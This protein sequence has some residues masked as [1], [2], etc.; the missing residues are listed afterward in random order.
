MAG[1]MNKKVCFA[2]VLK[3]YM[4]YKKFIDLSS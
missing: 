4:N 3:N 1:A 2:I